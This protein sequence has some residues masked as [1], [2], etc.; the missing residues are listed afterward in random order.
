[1]KPTVGEDWCEEVEKKSSMNL[2]KRR[3]E[4]WA[5]EISELMVRP[6]GGG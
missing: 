3:V 1:M 4:E 2:Y 6:H 5:R